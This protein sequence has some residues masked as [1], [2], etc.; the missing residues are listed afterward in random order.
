LR[1]LRSTIFDC[2]LTFRRRAEDLRNKPRRDRLPLSCLDDDCRLPPFAFECLAKFVLVKDLT[3]TFD[4]PPLWIG[5]LTA[6]RTGGPGKFV[7]LLLQVKNLF[8]QIYDVTRAELWE[9]DSVLG[10][11]ELTP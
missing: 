8:L 5:N 10:D 4:P 2:L 6:V 9:L 11:I 7:E 3:E 1:A